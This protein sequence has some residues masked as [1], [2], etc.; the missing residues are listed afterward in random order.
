LK[1]ALLVRKRSSHA[2]LARRPSARAARLKQPSLVGRV[3]LVFRQLGEPSRGRNRL[4]AV[5]AVSGQNVAVGS[6]HRRKS[7]PYPCGLAEDTVT[8]K[9][10]R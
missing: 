2:Q 4:S 6:V 8:N 1:A 7:I 3:V 5:H 9:K 10:G